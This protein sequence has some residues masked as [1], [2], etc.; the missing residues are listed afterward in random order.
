[1]PNHDLLDKIP[2]GYVEEDKSAQELI[3][4]GLAGDIV[5]R[6]IPMVDLN[7]Y[8]RRQFSPGVRISVQGIWQG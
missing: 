5:N 3:D 7:E 8:K 1:M 2:Q 4:P 6:V